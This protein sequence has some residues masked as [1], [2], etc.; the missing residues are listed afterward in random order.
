M[1]K[2]HT[3]IF[4]AA[5]GLLATFFEPFIASALA[6]D[7]TDPVVWANEGGDKVT[8]DE[9]RA[10]S[11]RDVKNSIWDG[12]KVRLFGARNEV[13][14]FNLVLECKETLAD[15]SVEFDC[16]T[17]QNH[18]IRSRSAS[19]DEVFQSVDRPIELFYVRYLPINGLSDMGYETYDERHVPRRFQR[20][21][22]MEGI[23]AIGTGLWT[24]RPDHDKYYPDILIPL[25][26]KRTFSISGKSNQ[27]IWADIY[28]PKDALKGIY[29]GELKIVEHAGAQSARRVLKTVQIELK[30][31]DFE[32]PDVPSIKTVTFMDTGDI[33]ERFVGVRYPQGNSQDEKTAVAV[34]Q[35]YVQ[36][37]H[38][39]RIEM[40]DK[41]EGALG[42]H[43]DR[44]RKEW[45]SR[46]DGS[47]FTPANGYAG[48][49]SGVGNSVFSVGTYGS[50]RALWNW[51]ALNEEQRKS[52]FAKHVAEWESWFQK[53]SPNTLRILY[54]WDEPS[55]Q[56]YAQVDTLAQW[57]KGHLKSF[58][59]LDLLKAAQKAPS[60]DVIASAMGCGP[61]SWGQ[62][63][64]G[65]KAQG[66]SVWFY[67]GQRPASGS[68]M[69]EDDGVALRQL[70]WGQ[71]KLGI[72]RWFYWQSCYYNDSNHGKGPT[73]VFRTAATFTGPV[74]N[75]PIRGQTGAH[76]SNG[77]GLLIYPG[78]DLVFPKESYNALGPLASLRM[79]LWRRGIQDGDY[80]TMAAAK[81]PVRV[82]AIVDE[83][84]KK[85]MWEY[86]VTNPIDP[87][88]VHEDIS[89]TLNPDAW[90]KA[91][92]EL[93][94]IID[95]STSP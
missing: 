17:N 28:I 4:L 83:M 9:T 55:D 34:R 46:L 87:T 78:T 7:P 51:D 27:S 25:E 52:Q 63:L 74:H 11:G 49:G 73:N 35:K 18:K 70:A 80:L 32:L 59:T 1:M 89:W 19:G 31:H 66:K 22:K 16:L 20:P 92:Q 62:A 48:P 86:G 76:Y 79:K 69:I 50:W 72:D 21:F 84:V 75:D 5:L 65:A 15:I 64:Q 81:N 53:N 40:I 61:A 43:D 23:K 47:L 77:D 93:A 26:L 67:N 44:P 68:F 29:V 54:L 58:A 6:N 37:A 95:P 41:N 85:A 56:D 2:I 24:D 82:K 3:R 10:L 88:Y 8:Q 30:V 60:V 90:E 71:Y 13:L 91:R 94:R 39:H 36:M 14:G 57:S 45:E 12:S 38:R 42:L 33:E